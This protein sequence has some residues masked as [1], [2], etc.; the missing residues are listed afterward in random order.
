MKTIRHC[1]LLGLALLLASCASFAGAAQTTQTRPF[2]GVRLIHRHQTQP[3]LLDMF[4]VEINL[5]DPA[6]RFKVTPSNGPDVPGETTVETTRAFATR[7]K[8]QLAINTSFFSIGTA[9]YVDN[10]NVAVSDGERYS[11]FSKG[12]PALNISEDNVATIVEG[13]PTDKSGYGSMPRVA[14]WNAAGG[15]EWILK[16][17]VN[18]ARDRSLHPRTAAGVTSD[19]RLLLL[20]VDGRNPLRSLGLTTPE[21]AEILKEYG[22]V[23]ALNLDGGG[24]STLVVADPAPR[25]VNVPV[26]LKNIPG[27]ERPVGMSLA[28]YA[29]PAAGRDGNNGNNGMNGKNGKKKALAASEAKPAGKMIRVTPIIKKDLRLRRITRP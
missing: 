6:I 11:K 14:L 16:H 10:L 7:M 28:V 26:G 5:K 24:S 27:T 21:E 9:P 1:A 19:S 23:D 2:R 25:V 29:A 8:A 13:D 17:G 3:R 18:V 15:N 4:I 22:A 12:Q 20:V